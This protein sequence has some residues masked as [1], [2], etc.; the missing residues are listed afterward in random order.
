MTSRLTTSPKFW[1]TFSSSLHS[2]LKVTLYPNALGAVIENSQSES[3]RSDISMCAIIFLFQEKKYAVAEELFTYY[4][5]TKNGQQTEDTLSAKFNIAYCQM[6][7]GSFAKSEASWRELLSISAEV[8]DNIKSQLSNLG[9]RSNLGMVLNKQGKFLEAEGVLR[10]LLPEMQKKF[11][12]SDPRAL[13]C[14]RHLREALI[15]QGKVD[16]A[17]FLL[18]EGMELAKS[19]GEL[20]RG[21]EIEAMDEFRRDLVQGY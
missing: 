4:Y 10:E 13:G 21:D 18:G 14:L 20:H 15:G 9:E 5:E 12:H 1:T 11:D 8:I 3:S 7:Q 16:E 2:E 17:G 6:E 19:C